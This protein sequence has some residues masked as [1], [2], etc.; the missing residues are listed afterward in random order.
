[1]CSCPQQTSVLLLPSVWLDGFFFFLMIRRPPRS[2]LFP[3]TTLFRS[4]DLEVRR[5][6]LSVTASGAIGA[7]GAGREPQINAHVAV[8]D[9]D[10]ALLA[11]LLG[12]RALAASGAPAAQLTAG[13][14]AS[15]DLEWRGPLAAAQP[16]WTPGGTGFRGAVG[17]RDATLA[18]SDP[19]PDTQH[20]DARIEWHGP[21]MHAA[22]DGGQVGTFQLVAASA[23]WDARGRAMHLAG[24]VTGSAQQA[25]AWLR[26]HPQLSA[27][28]PGLQDVDLRGDTLLDVDVLVRQ[29]RVRMRVTAV[30]DGAQ[31]HAGAGPPP[32]DA[33]RG[34]PAFSA[35]P[36]QPPT[37]TRPWL[38][39][40]GSPRA[41]GRGAPDVTA[42]VISG[43]GLVDVRQAVL[44]AGASD[45]GQLAG[46]A[47]L[48]A[49]LRFLP[50]A[51]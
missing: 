42:L 32:I 29:P 24:R 27:Y 49:A 14:I 41:P 11:R 3:Y 19:W 51:A 39:G 15:A 31:L 18:G 26:Q 7:A 40:P 43:R 34:P 1:M 36:P 37:P 4:D 44:A 38:G 22:I 20:L 30:L 10:V 13:R 17:L 48:S 25:L 16:P 21:S 5:A 35:R 8:K 9:A 12:A 28:A 50:A 47:G 6:Q 33:L 2:T 23:E 46:N 45:D